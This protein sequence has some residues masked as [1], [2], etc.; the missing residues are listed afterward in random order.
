MRSMAHL[1]RKQTALR[2]L[3]G[4]IVAWTVGFGALTVPEASGLTPTEATASGAEAPMFEEQDVLNAGTLG[5]ACFRIPTVVKAND[6]TLLMFAEGRVNNCSDT[7][8]IDL[9]LTRS[10]DGGQTWSPLDVVIEGNGETRGNPTPVVHRESGRISLLSMRNPGT[11]WTPRTP[12]LQHSEDNG[13]TWSDPVDI[14]AQVSRPEWAY[15]YATGP[16]HGIQLQRGAHPGR[17]VAPVYFSP[18]SE[19]E[20]GNGLIYSDDGGLTWELG[21]IDTQDSELAGESTAVELTDGRLYVSTRSGPLTFEHVGHRGYAI[22]S[23]GGQTFD[24]P[25][26]EETQ[27]PG[28]INQAALLRLSARDE[29]DD[30]NRIVYSSPAHPAAREAMTIRSSHDEART[31]ETWE[32]GKVIHWGPSAYSDLVEIDD[33]VVGLAYEAGDFSPYESIRFARLN[34]AF[35]DTP[36]QT[37]P[38]LP[39]PPEP[40][41]TTPDTAPRSDVTAYVRGGAELSDGRTGSALAFDGSDDHLELPLTRST[42]LAADNFTWATWLKYS[43]TSGNHALVWAH[44]IGP[45]TTPGAW[46]RAEPGSNRI[47]ASLGTGW[48]NA[49]TVS[50]RVA[51]NDDQWHHVVFR[52][53]DDWL[54]LYVD[55]NQVARAAA[56]YGSITEGKEFGI[57]GLHLGQRIDGVDRLRGSLDE[58][59]IYRRA[60]STAEIGRLAAG[61]RPVARRLEVRLPFD[62]IDPAS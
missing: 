12:Y 7:G 34:E 49:R 48:S 16:V 45:G 36:N 33:G 61:H 22:S 8:D 20:R 21:A 39:G 4:S 24:A 6:G 42:D 57:E 14:S 41:P 52:R 56:P 2:A 35:L 5:Y 60:L 23:D 38:N 40:G 27:L 18:P 62:R 58:T 59:L 53:S 51:Y 46:L 50:S 44:K 15:W 25:V 1:T 28:P 19:T 10:T 32:E 29:G 26:A 55:G 47:R 9:V 37:P 31:W 54:T 30:A 3:T 17:L 43:A 11:S 13:V